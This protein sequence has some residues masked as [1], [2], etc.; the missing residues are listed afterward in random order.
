MKTTEN[1]QIL[2][3]QQTPAFSV[4]PVPP[5]QADVRDKVFAALYLPLAYCFVAVCTGGLRV[6]IGFAIFTV[7]YAAVVLG[8]LYARGMRPPAESWLWLGVMLCLAIPLVWYT[9]LGIFQILL[10][11]AVAA[12]WTLCAGGRLT[13]GKTSDWLMLDLL[14]ALVLVP[15][16]NFFCLPSVLLHGLRNKRA[17]RSVAYI[18]LGLLL[19]VPLLCLVLPELSAADSS[20]RAM[21]HSIFSSFRGNPLL[22]LRLMLTVPVALY[23]F[24][25]VYGAVRGRRTALAKRTAVSKLQH[26]LHVLPNLAACTAAGVLCAVYL[27]FMVFQARYLFSGLMGRLPEEYTFAEYAR[28]GFLELCRIVML[29]LSLLIGMNALAKAPRAASRALRVWNVVLSVLTLLLLVTAAGK[30]GLYMGTYGLTQMRVLVSVFLLWLGIVFG[31][32]LLWQWKQFNIVRVCVAAGTILVCVLCVIDVGG[33]IRFYNI[34]TQ[35]M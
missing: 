24:G 13:M 26:K 10:L 29:N 28:S 9:V 31:A 7:A 21:L 11:I 1:T 3:P 18:A 35:I 16:G 34:T 27:L 30:M 33:W 19:A 6:E 4:P 23:L 14:H 25:L 5:V 32:L 2:Q 17:G 20:F 15:F 22:F 8:Y 12:Y